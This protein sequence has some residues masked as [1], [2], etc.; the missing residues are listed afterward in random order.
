MCKTSPVCALDTV[1]K[2]SP[3]CSRDTGCKTPVCARNTVC[4]TSPVR[5]L[6]TVCKNWTLNAGSN[7]CLSEHYTPEVKL[8]DGDLGSMLFDTRR[9]RQP[10]KRPKGQAEQ[11]AGRPRRRTGISGVARHHGVRTSCVDRGTNLSCCTALAPTST[12]ALFVY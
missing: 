6:D 5:A 11:G 4:K 1:C 12:Y 7:T 8:A 2:N 10:P 3:V 9:L